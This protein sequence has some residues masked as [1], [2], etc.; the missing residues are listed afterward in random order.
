MSD[1]VSILVY[2]RDPVVLETRRM[3]LETTGASVVATTGWEQAQQV[4]SNPSL[5]LLV[6]CYTLSS[7][8]RQSILQFAQGIRPEITTL[9]LR[10]DGQSSADFGKDTLDV[11]AGP[12]AFKAKVMELLQRTH[13]GH[14]KRTNPGDL[15]R[16]QHEE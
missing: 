6:L 9:V 8:D 14:L 13:S 7:E 11:F 10:A 12:R 2:G 5:D 1:E 15:L 4:I 3:V 16:S